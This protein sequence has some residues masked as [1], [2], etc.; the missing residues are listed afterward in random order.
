L[1]LALDGGQLYADYNTSMGDFSF[2]FNY[3][4][5]N[6]DDKELLIEASYQALQI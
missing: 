5:V 2:K 4:W 6:A 1:F 3:G